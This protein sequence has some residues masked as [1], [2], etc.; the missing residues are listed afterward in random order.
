MQKGTGYYMRSS[1]SELG[2]PVGKPVSILHVKGEQK[3]RPSS[4]LVVC[5]CSL[6]SICLDCFMIFAPTRH[7]CVIVFV[8]CSC[9]I[10]L[11][12]ILCLVWIF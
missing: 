6:F 10:S 8:K 1:Q 7:E 12:L 11:C 2:R 4:F 5:S 3:F 9:L